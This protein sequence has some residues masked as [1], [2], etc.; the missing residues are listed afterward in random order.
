[1]GDADQGIGGQGGGY[2]PAGYGWNDWL[3]SG[4]RAVR[5][6][7][8]AI[9][10]AGRRVQFILWRGF[11]QM[12]DRL[13]IT[14]A[15]GIGNAVIELTPPEAQEVDSYL[16][17]GPPPTSPKLAVIPEYVNRSR[18]DWGFPV[19]KIPIAPGFGDSWGPMLLVAGV[20]LVMLA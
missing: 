1:M 5:A 19:Q 18:N 14:N 8:E 12:P 13:S 7:A 9:D 16:S 6:A 11:Q 2:V 20:V 10:N 15:P 17:G 4:Q 3:P